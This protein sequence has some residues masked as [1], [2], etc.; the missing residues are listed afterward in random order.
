MS[1]V[2]AAYQKIQRLILCNIP[3][4]PLHMHA[5]PRGKEVESGTEISWHTMSSLHSQLDS[6]VD[7]TSC[8]QAAM[9]SWEDVTSGPRGQAR[10]ALLISEHSLLVDAS[11]RFLTAFVG[12]LRLQFPLHNL[13]DQ[14]FF[15]DIGHL[16]HNVMS[17]RSAVLVWPHSWPSE[18]LQG[19]AALGSAMVL[20]VKWAL[21][22]QQSSYHSGWAA[23]M[24]SMIGLPLPRQNCWSGSNVNPPAL[25]GL[26]ITP[27]LIPIIFH[28]VCVILRAES[29]VSSPSIQLG[30]FFSAVGSTHNLISTVMKWLPSGFETP[31]MAQLEN[32]LLGG[33]TLEAVK[34]LLVAC[35]DHDPQAWANKLGPP[36]MLLNML[37]LCQSH[38]CAQLASLD[39]SCR[40][41]GNSMG[42]TSG[43]IGSTQQLYFTTSDELLMRTLKII[44]TLH[45]S[46]RKTIELVLCDIEWGGAASLA[47]S[48][49]NSAVG[50]MQVMAQDVTLRTLLWMRSEQKL[51]LM[52][53]WALETKHVQA[54]FAHKQLA[55]ENSLALELSI[56][57][58]QPPVRLQQRR[59]RA[60]DVMQST[61]AAIEQVYQEKLQ[62]WELLRSSK[63]AELQE[64][65]ELNT[66]MRDKFNCLHQKLSTTQAE[67]TE[68]IQRTTRAIDRGLPFILSRVI[69]FMEATHNI[70]TPGRLFCGISSSFASLL[71]FVILCKFLTNRCCVCPINQFDAWLL[72][73][74]R[75]CCD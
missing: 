31:V 69:T 4:P 2:V 5:S 74:D 43:C 7:V 52:K 19:N 38:C 36:T 18:H 59:R 49:S 26:M 21:E 9:G 16:W 64:A 15:H 11:A 14:L 51:I 30:T 42:A 34:L 66:A 23:L 29:T 40:N 45:P 46:T 33:F 75:S 39:F 53:G 22:L 65:E 41:A 54:R 3:Q 10:A 60:G 37:C 24:L 56:L 70:A 58:S 57:Q 72:L 44:S 32:E 48:P 25:A 27:G 68:V 6:I 8:T 17:I 12:Q 47:S 73:S 63:R 1:D 67:L 55:K 61:P 20:L 35:A 62:A 13:C 71:F 50:C 28:L